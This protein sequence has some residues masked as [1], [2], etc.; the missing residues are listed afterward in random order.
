[1]L[2]R[3][4]GTRGSVASAGPET[5]RYGG[6]TA[7]VELRTDDG[8]L[9]VFDCGTG[10]RKLGLS[11]ADSEPVVVHLFVG[12][13]HA[14]HIQGFP[15]FLPAYRPGNQI[16]VYGPSG[17]DRSFPSAMGGQMDFAYFPVP[18]RALAARIDL[19]ELGECEFSIPQDG[20]SISVRTQW[21]NHTAPCLGYRIA[22]G[23]RTLVYSTDHEAYSPNRHHAEA[24]PE[25]GR[26]DRFL[27][28][29]DQRHAEFLR[30]ADLVIHDTQ[31]TAGDYPASAGWGHSTVEYVT[32]LAIAAGVRRLALFHH[33][34][35]RD[36]RAVD[37]M[38]AFA[39]DRAK[40]A[41]ADL[42]VVAAAEGAEVAIADRSAP[43]S[44]S[45]IPSA[46]R[47]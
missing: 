38:A 7:C 33:D 19:V 8:T 12:H 29:G 35:A 10:I 13:T 18:L 6:N 25:R 31:Y 15:F 4:W 20:P 5:V 30:D 14:D 28:A 40:A 16:V 21:L 45:R 32:D 41:G 47:V 27:H 37:E 3:F 11:L 23:G 24:P 42:E 43:V 9:M 2:V 36:D 17:M 22:C 1:M 39:C 34:P 46:A 44:A 26:I